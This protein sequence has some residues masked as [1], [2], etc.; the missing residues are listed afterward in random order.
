MNEKQTKII[1]ALHVK[2]QVNPEE[3]VVRR[4]SFLKNYLK[5]HPF[6]KSLIL[7]ISGGQDSTLAGKLAQLAITELREETGDTSYQ[8]IAVRLPYGIQND[9]V[10]A[11]KAIEFIQPDVSLVVN[12]KTMV[13]ALQSELLEQS[14]IIVHD[15]NKG[16]VKARARMIAQY[17]V[18]G[19]RLGIVLGTD[20][21]AENL[22]GF[23]TKFG[24]GAADVL[25][26][27]GLNKRQGRQ[28]LAYLGADSS[29]YL[30][31]PTADLEEDRPMIAD[32]TALG[33]KY[34]AID[35]YLEGREVSEEDRQTIEG[36][37]DITEHKRQLPI[38]MYTKFWKQGKG[39]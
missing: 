26:L 37:Y 13:D 3:E 24:D 35:D 31:V 18:A 36:W 15:Y 38:S 27:F 8:F 25:P 7:G 12:I 29:L 34:E 22:T 6:I 32:E 16:N 23:Y 17:A 4:V 21:A 2:P 30:K 9:E 11:L 10:D 39:N 20:H 14:N 28:V 1:K 5:K 33:V 19:E